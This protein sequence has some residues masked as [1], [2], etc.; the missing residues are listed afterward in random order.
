MGKPESRIIPRRQ[1]LKSGAAL[2]A[3]AVAID[4]AVAPAVAAGKNKILGSNED[5]LVGVIGTGNM[6]RAN[7]MAFA[8]VENVRVAA[9]CDCYQRNLD[10]ALEKLEEE[11]KPK[12][13]T[14]SDFRKLIEMK[15][16]DVVVVA[17]P[18]HWHPLMAVMACRAGK[19]VYVEKPVSVAVSEGRKMVEVAR[20][21]KRVVGVGTQQ[22]SGEHFQRA[23]EIVRSGRLGRITRVQT[24]NY[25]NEYPEGFGNPPDSDPPEGLDWDM[26]LGPAPRRPFNK[27][28]FGVDVEGFW[29]TFR[30]FWDYAGGWMT[31]W[32]THL[33]DVVQWAME[34]NGPE[35]VFASG[36]K[37]AVLDNR[38]TPDTM[39]AIFEYPG[40]ICTYEF[41]GCSR[42]TADGRNYGILFHGTEASLFVDRSGYSLTPEMEEFGE[43]SQ[44]KTLPLSSGDS[45][46]HQTHVKAFIDCVKSRKPFVSD[47]EVGHYASATPHLAN[48]SLR[49]GRRLKYDLKNERFVGDDQA[50]GMLAR[51][52]RAPWKLA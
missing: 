49:L 43:E 12:P 37:Y 36:G 3:A 52:Y 32:G 31:D 1:L 10:R 25:V 34:T 51:E 13:Q 44:A 6:G 26:W 45:E 5:L 15:D 4:G 40:F 42:E 27:S 29:S 2:A 39:L 21:T 20:E 50:N 30:W 24:W 14:F 28:R 46:Q 41:R 38:E 8:E 19:D 47:I 48:I 9:V 17:T 23:V 35:H 11:E 18:D 22:R 33:I 7:M 16:L